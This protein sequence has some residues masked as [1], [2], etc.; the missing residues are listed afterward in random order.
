[1]SDTTT[2]PFGKALNAGLRKALADDPRVL[3]MG[4]DIGPLGGV[5]RVTEGLQAEFGDRRV[6]DTPL[7]ESGILGTAIGLAMAGFRPVCE[8][9][10]DG[11]VFPAFDQ[12]TSQLAKMTNRHEGVLSM[13]IVI[14]IPYGGHIGAVEH[15]QESPETYFT[16]T[17]GLRVVSPST[18]NDAYW[19]IQEAIASNDPVVF[20]EPKS[21]YWHKGEV[22]LEASALPLHASR[23][24]RRGTD[25][26]LV[27]HGA[28]VSVLLQ[29]AALAES[30]G[31]SC[32]VVDVR[33]LSP[34]D[35]GP[36]LESVRR[37]G[38]M[39]YAQEAPGFVSVGSEVAATVA[40]KA[41]Y[42]LEAPV[43][44]VSG[45]DTPFPPAKL[46]GVYLPDPDRILE[47]VD[48]SLAY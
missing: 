7:A 18:A 15:H 29:A 26:T 10:F 47:A 2:L 13:P 39:V 34:I 28:M 12:I 36:V 3:L 19:M 17:P 35:Y 1:M 11:F 42:A 25:V 46:E 9:Q 14:R 31:T 16:H 24:V 8:I 21:R 43:I 23:I 5:F 41:F 20:L 22:D 27:G 30:E 33:S 48:R 6:I 44:R 32:E 45:F 37:T 38:R 4:E 40:E